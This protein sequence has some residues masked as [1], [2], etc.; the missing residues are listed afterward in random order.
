MCGC[1]LPTRSI[2]TALP[3]TTRTCTRRVEAPNPELEREM[4]PATTEQE[5]L[6]RY[7]LMHVNKPELTGVYEGEIGTLGFVKVVQVIGDE[8][9]LCEF[10][11]GEGSVVEETHVIWVNGHLTAGLVDGSSVYLDCIQIVGRKQYDSAS[12]P[13]TVF[14]VR[15]FDFAPYLIKTGAQ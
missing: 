11:E 10:V 15:P 4:G 5:Q 6:F 8:D 12:G 13:K 7:F 14:L 3:S 2:A 9:M 1:R